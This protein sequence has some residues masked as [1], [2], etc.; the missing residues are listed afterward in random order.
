MYEI[1]SEKGKSSIHTGGATGSLKARGFSGA[2][3]PGLCPPRF[4]GLRAAWQGV[5]F[6]GVANSK[7]GAL[8]TLLG[9]SGHTWRGL[10]GLC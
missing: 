7:N 8:G 6:L 3:H 5:V 9:P 10:L 4:G 1:K 2:G